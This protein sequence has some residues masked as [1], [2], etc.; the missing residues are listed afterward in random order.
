MQVEPPI[1][2]NFPPPQVNMVAPQPL[3]PLIWQSAIQQ[4]AQ[5]HLMMMNQPHYLPQQFV[6]NQTQIQ[7]V[8]MI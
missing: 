2:N 4:Y 7:P 5:M 3:S 8:Q 6:P 1:E